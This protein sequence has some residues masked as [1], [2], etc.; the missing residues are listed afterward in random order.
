MNNQEIN[1]I[2][3]G[4]LLEAPK[5]EIDEPLKDIIAAWPDEDIKAIHILKAVD[6]LVFFA[7]ASPFVHGILDMMLI[8]TL[9]HEGTTLKD[10]EPLATWRW[11][12]EH[13][14]PS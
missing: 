1:L 9:K 3:K 11:D 4:E 12:W 6:N 5:G 7:S 13:I 14:T 2:L 8:E 10:I